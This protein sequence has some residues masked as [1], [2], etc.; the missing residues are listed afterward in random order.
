MKNILT[1]P[2]MVFLMLPWCTLAQNLET[3]LKKHY[4]AMGQEKMREIETIEMIGEMK[5]QEQVIP[6]RTVKKRPDKSRIET[7]V[8]GLTMVQAYDGKTVWTLTPYSEIAVALPAE[9]AKQ[10]IQQSDM[11]GPLV[12]YKAKGYTIEYLGEEIYQ[13]IKCH[14]LKVSV[15]DG[16]D[17][18][19]YFYLDA[20]SYL[21]RFQ[22]ITT[23]DN[24]KAMTVVNELSGYENRSGINIP[25][26]F[27]T[28]LNGVEQMVMT[29]KAVNF[30]IAI[31]DAYFEMP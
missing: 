2:T 17:D 13:D 19:V 23:T 4:D 16:G 6:V 9:Q 25:F 15:P 26:L 14:K 12:N 18:D 31:T 7:Q 30:D 21:L 20:D 22:H 5:V 8:N 27:T 10:I 28:R 3:V 29:I 24:G 11:D 1:I